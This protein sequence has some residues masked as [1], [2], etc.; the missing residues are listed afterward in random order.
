MSIQNGIN[1]KVKTAVRE[2]SPNCGDCSGFNC[3]I[4]IENNKAVCSKLDVIKTSKP[5]QQFVPNPKNVEGAGNLGALADLIH[6]MTPEARRALGVLLFNEDKTIKQKL[7]F[8]QKVFVRYRG[9][10]NR[11]YLSNFMEAYV[12]YATAKTFKL[13]SM[14]GRCVM[15]FGEHCKPII[16]TETDFDEMSAKMIRKGALVDPDIEQLIS[17]RFRCEEEYDLNLV[18]KEDPSTVSTIDQVF[19][20]NGIKKARKKGLPDLISLVDEAA[21]GYSVKGK[22]KIYDTE[23]KRSRASGGDVIVDVSGGH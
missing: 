10:S 11:N 13:M 16:H 3:D 9:A 14:D 2:V 4:L 17:R 7:R 1:A 20:G 23:S 8:M 15:T 22:A 19:A 12:M 21:A 5:C 6:T 18:D